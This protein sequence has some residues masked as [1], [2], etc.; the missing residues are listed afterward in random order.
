MKWDIKKALVFLLIVLVTGS[1][2]DK[3]GGEA[4]ETF[5]TDGY[6][7]WGGDPAVD[8]SGW[9]FSTRANRHFEYALQNLAD[10]LKTDSLFVNACLKKTE[11][12][13]TCEC[14]QPYY[15]FSLVS[16]QKK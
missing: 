15:Y 8:G 16:V 1:A 9:Y 12:R 3:E 4:E 2:C 13:F 7:F 14:T 5:C 6:I 11:N 10:S